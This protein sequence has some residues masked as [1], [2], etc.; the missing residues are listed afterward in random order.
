M[1]GNKTCDACGKETSTFVTAVKLG[2]VKVFCQECVANYLQV[3]L[4]RIVNLMWW[5]KNNGPNPG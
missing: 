5:A 3:S 1:S 4:D 2:E